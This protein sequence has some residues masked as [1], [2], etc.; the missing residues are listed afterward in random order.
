MATVNL[1]VTAIESQTGWDTISVANLS[2][3]NDVRAT[4][5][6]AGDVFVVTLDDVP[7]DFGSQNSITI[8]IEARHLGLFVNREKQIQFD[9]LDSANNVLQSTS[10]GNITG[11]TDVVYT[12]AVLERTDSAAVINGYKIRATVTEGGGMPDD[13]TIEVDHVYATL[14]YNAATP[15]QEIPVGLVTETDTPFATSFS[16]L[17]SAGI[18]TESSSSLILEKLKQ[19]LVGLNTETDSTF[20]VLSVVQVQVGLTTETDTSLIV[21]KVKEK[22]LGLTTETDESLQLTSVINIP[23]GIISEIS[24]SQSME[25]SKL[26]GIGL[27]QETDS[28]LILVSAKLKQTGLALE[29]D[30]SLSLILVSVKDIVAKDWTLYTWADGTQRSWP[31]P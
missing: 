25:I 20:V 9:L 5:G 30:S 12:S 11:E 15:P 18:T 28:G 7:G 2:T 27:S 6:V 19:K 4:N 31:E 22:L 3:S 29:T 13:A 10:T 16:K 26:L 14:D 23:V 8:S 1:Q 17:K 24:L 21:Q